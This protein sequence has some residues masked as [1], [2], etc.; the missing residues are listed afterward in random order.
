MELKLTMRK[1]KEGDIE[2]IKVRK[3]QLDVH[4]KFLKNSKAITNMVSRFDIPLY[5][6]TD[7]ESDKII[8]ISGI[9]PLDV[10]RGISRD[11]THG[12]AFMLSSDSVKEYAKEIY[13]HGNALM[14][15]LSGY[16]VS[17]RSKS[18]KNFPIAGEFLVNLGFKKVGEDSKNIIYEYKLDT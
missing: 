10:G 14:T 6:Y 5:T 2:N 18:R 13:M 12:E 3:E 1:F 9:I 4:S 8:L 17:I 7:K 15:S 11:F 16:F